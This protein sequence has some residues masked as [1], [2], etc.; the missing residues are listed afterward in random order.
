MK[1]PKEIKIEDY[2]YNLPKEKIAQF[3]LEERDASRVLIYK[4]KEISETIFKDISDNLPDGSFL[5]LNNTKVIQAR[6][7]FYKET[8]AMIEIFCL[9][10]HH[11]EQNISAKG[12]AVWKCFVGN[13]GKWKYGPLIKI[14][15]HNSKEYELS[16]EILEREKDYFIINFDWSN[17][18]ISFGDILLHTGRTPLPPYIR[19]E[20]VRI[21]TDRYQTVY[22]EIDGSVA[23]PTAG[24]HFTENVF[25]KIKKKNI[26]IHHVTL[27]VGAGT[28]KPV[29]CEKIEDH[30]MHYEHIT[31]SKDFVIKLLNNLNK[32]VIAAG[33][34]SLRTIE[35]L[36]WLGLKLHLNLLPN[37]DALNVDQWEPYTLDSSISAMESLEVILKFM[38]K[39]GMDY[40]TAQTGILIAPGYDFKFIDILITNFHLPK[41]TL[42][43]LIAAFT[44]ID[45][46]RIYEYAL[47]NN[48]RFLSYGDAS[49]LRR[50]SSI[51]NLQ[52]SM[53]NN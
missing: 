19:R 34:T 14:F 10:P 9:E 2:N 30:P 39:S 20:P 31:V 13:A 50:Q 15:T 36:Y 27:N 16:A 45:W 43:L 11:P 3:P 22:A 29:K 41:S 26:Y 18:N 1:D 25:K 7:F 35:T 4:D 40:I 28:F 49:L 46:K 33:T 17:N 38:D 47:E 51:V 48:F 32:P 12:S 37:Q 53:K 6:L 24:L 42:L 21:D 23:A 44:G 8:G 52:T 5:I